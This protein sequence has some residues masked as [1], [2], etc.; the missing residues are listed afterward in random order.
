MGFAAAYLVSEAYLDRDAASAAAIQQARTAAAS[1]PEVEHH[2]RDGARLLLELLGQMPEVRSAD[3]AQCGAALARVLKLQPRYNN[4]LVASLDGTV[5]CSA[6]PLKRPVNVADRPWFQ[7]VSKTRDLVEGGFIVGRI[8]GKPQRPYALPFVDPASGSTKFVNALLDLVWF[9]KTLGDIP[10]P[11]NS[12][13]GI[14]DSGGRQLARFPDPERYVG[15]DVRGT[16]MYRQLLAHKDGGAFRVVG[17]DGIERLY[18][19]IAPSAD[20]SHLASDYAYVGIPTAAIFAETRMELRNRLLGLGILGSLLLIGSYMASEALI[21]RPLNALVT[22][23]RRIA[24][25][26]FSARSGLRHATLEYRALADSF[27]SMAASLANRAALL[28]Q[29]ILEHRQT[30]E[31]L[32]ASEE[33][34]RSFTEI[35]SHWHWE[36]DAELRIREVSEGYD[37][38]SGLRVANV[39]GRKMWEAAGDGDPPTTALWAAL[40]ARLLARERIRDFRYSVAVEGGQMRYRRVSAVP[41][42]DREGRFDGYRCVSN[43]ETAEVEASRRAR[44]AEELLA[45][46]VESIPDGFA[47]FDAADRL[48]MMNA[49]YREFLRPGIA[50]GAIGKTF[51]ELVKAHLNQGH[52]PEAV[53]R[54]QEFLQERLAA[55]R[56]PD[57]AD[58]YRDSRG[59]WFLARD[60]QMA[61]GTIVAIRTDVTELAMID[62]ALRESQANL[63]QAQQVAKMGSWEIDLANSNESGDRAL[64]W[65]DETFRIFGYKPGEIEV[66]MDAFYRSVHPDDRERVR[67]A[68]AHARAT[69]EIYDLEHRVIRPDGREII[70]RERSKILYAPLT[71]K[72]VKIVGIV[73]DVTESRETTER[74]RRSQALLTEMER[75]AGVGGWE[76]DLKKGNFNCTEGLMAIFGLTSA[77]Q[78]LREGVSFKYVHPNDRERVER[79]FAAARSGEHAYSQQYR[80]I[81]RGGKEC[82]VIERGD[83]VRDEQGQPIRIVGAVM[84]ITE[85]SLAEEQLRQSQKLEVIGQLTGGVAHD[86]NNLLTIIIGNLELI[87]ERPQLQVAT[88]VPYIRMALQS[89]IG[90]SELVKRLLTVARQQPLETELVQTNP[91]IEGLMPLL[92]STLGENIAIRTHLASD[93]WP[94]LTDP[95]QMENALLNLVVNARD[96]MPNGGTLSIVT[97]NSRLDS[98][99]APTLPDLLPGEYMMLSV[100]DTGVGMPPEVRDRAL[101]AFFTTK[102]AG[103]GSGLGLAMV[104]GFVKQC[105]GQLLIYS[106][107]GQGTTVKLFLPRVQGSVTRRPTESPSEAPEGWERILLVE[108]DVGVRKTAARMLSDL[109]YTVGEATDAHSA[110]EAIRSGAVFDLLFTDYVMPGGMTGWDLAQ[111]V[112]QSKPGMPIL[113]TTGYSD[114]LIMQNAALDERVRLLSK[115]YTKR[116]LA[117]E[118]RRIL[119]PES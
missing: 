72:P 85:R 33:R 62:E 4:I 24:A 69:G 26:D 68:A 76:I 9:S 46:A 73:Q 78:P 81:R 58:L 47:I 108:D 66:T 32:R 83:F 28:D 22:L 19:V 27:D 20:P 8:T 37:N 21:V 94:V 48:A 50:E 110:L 112:W 54:E 101:E 111:M 45:H 88:V 41:I 17:I 1:V 105:G 115:P 75:I 13:Y 60:H 93:I 96:A 100:S 3:P 51:A 70:V 36:L 67:Q 102:G 38:F 35:A 119:D 31:S 42:F 23:S 43:D 95:G 79:E 103:K 107:V 39:R 56:Q 99:R 97:E 98:D 114:N 77:D 57:K 10:L 18:F 59:I 80:I 87:E 71:G 30:E 104:H 34:F 106:E 15:Q 16:A 2:I 29:E 25:G 116:D 92:R 53:G 86:F 82:M 63:L 117:L 118:L 90:G 52:Y 113:F 61:D 6:V 65:S 11:A 7:E 44:A 91:L 40:E 55:H 5:V 14:I 12:S 49:R 64:R 84:D 89:A 74:L 109:G